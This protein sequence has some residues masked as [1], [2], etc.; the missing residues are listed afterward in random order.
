[1]R[2]FPSSIAFIAL[3]IL[4]TACSTNGEQLYSG[5]IEGEEIPILAEVTGSVQALLADEGD[6][7]T[8][9]QPLVQIDDR[10]IQ[11]QMKEAKAGVQAA[12]AALDEGKAGTRNQEI[13]KTLSLLEQ[14]DVKMDNVNIQLSKLNDLLIQRKANI[15]Q[16][17]AQLESAEE[18]KIFY[19]DQ[20]I[21]IEKLYKNG[22]ASENELKVQEEQVNKATSS[23]NQLKAKLKEVESLY[24]MAKKDQSTYEN[25]IR[26]LQAN[27]KMQQAELS[28]Q[29]EGATNHTIIKLTSQLDQAKA[30]QEQIQIQLDKTNVTAPI[31]GIVLRRNI[32][33]GEVV[34]A[35]FQMY[36]LLEQ[37]KLK[38]KVY[39]PEMRLNE[40]TLGGKAEIFVDS[41]PDKAF[42]GKITYISNSAE[43][44]PKNVQTP[45]ER[46]K[47]VFEVI[48]EPT[49]GFRQLKP[50]MPADIRFLKKETEK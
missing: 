35:N 1:M 7:V 27:S 22:A 42:N 15:D 34:T 16:I 19:K 38:V 13:K 20:L 25:Q 12:K 40:V 3:F 18:T 6:T 44:T 4:M 8:K 17:K 32:S 37:N 2:K 48:V 33:V 10:L 21:K 14:N 45:E 9:G 5:T 26:E 30:K 49:E 41:Y 46:T 39:I 29:Q 11:A 23:V 36:T 47:M 31:D 50:G 43:F 28:L 24:A